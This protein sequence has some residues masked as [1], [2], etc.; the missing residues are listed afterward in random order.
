MDVLEEMAFHT[1]LLDVFLAGEGFLLVEA[2]FLQEDLR[3]FLGW[4]RISCNPW[5][6]LSIWKR[7]GV[8]GRIDGPARVSKSSRP[9]NA[10]RA[11][12]VRG[13]SAC[14]RRLDH[15]HW[16]FFAGHEFELFAMV[17]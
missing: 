1:G 5:C 6:W 11:V 17:G 8:A 9:S 12:R 4:R 3:W 15:Q 7:A 2:V 14:C 13:W 16:A 10:A